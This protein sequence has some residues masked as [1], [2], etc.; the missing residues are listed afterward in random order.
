MKRRCKQCHETN[1]KC[2]Y[3]DLLEIT[4]D[5]G[6]ELLSNKEDIGGDDKL[7]ETQIRDRIKTKYCKKHK[8]KLIRIPYWDFD[9]IESILEEILNKFD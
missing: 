6:Y 3:E 8:I 5:R 1:R 4:K 2:T 7:E 9:R